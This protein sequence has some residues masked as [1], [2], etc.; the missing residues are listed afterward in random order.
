LKAMG[1]SENLRKVIESRGLRLTKI[2]SATGIPMSTLSEWTAGRDPIVS[3]ALVRL[4]RYLGVTLDELIVSEA[5][6]NGGKREVAQV[7]IQ[8]DGCEY[9]INFIKIK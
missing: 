6:A 5:I 2:S 4:C 9:Q 7:Q 8:L 1:F 3:D